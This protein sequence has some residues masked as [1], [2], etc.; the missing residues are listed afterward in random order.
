MKRTH[1]WGGNLVA[2]TVRD[3]VQEGLA[4]DPVGGKA[5]RIGVGVAVEGGLGAVS[6]VSGQALDAVAAAVSLVT[7][8]DGFDYADA[9][10][11][12]NHVLANL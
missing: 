6:L 1:Q 11:A 9:L 2:H 5:A 12:Q 10:V 4:P 7:P 8:P 3:L